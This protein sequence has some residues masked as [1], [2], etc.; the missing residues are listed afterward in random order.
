M[1]D[2][3]NRN[4][5]G[6]DNILLSDV[7]PNFAFS[8]ALSRYFR[9]PDLSS[10]L[11]T[12]LVTVEAVISDDPEVFGNSVSGVLIRALLKFPVVLKALVAKWQDKT[13]LDWLRLFSQAPFTD[14][15]ELPVIGRL[16]E[17]Y[18]EHAA[19]FWR[20]DVL[21]GWMFACAEKAVLLAKDAR[22][23][24]FRK[25]HPA[26]LRAPVQISLLDRYKDVLA[27]EFNSSIADFVLP[28]SI[29][30][31]DDYVMSI[32][33]PNYIRNGRRPGAESA[34][35]ANV[36]LDSNPVLVFLQTL[37]PW[38]RVDTSGTQAQPVTVGGLVERL[39]DAFGG[40]AGNAGEAAQ[41]RGPRDED[42]DVDGEI[43]MDE[44]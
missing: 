23:S 25:R 39:R 18:A 2:S 20:P 15:A 12:E 35:P 7:L 27:A 6:K 13:R 37:L 17:A 41:Q 5:L 43:D 28:K 44:Q 36:S 19:S 8:V 24:E 21:Q 33:R 26:S 30:D 42:D 16:S 34:G 1:L 4:F 40:L 22:V 38:A 3:W 11:G 29:I 10:G 14:G 31:N 32:Y 9:L